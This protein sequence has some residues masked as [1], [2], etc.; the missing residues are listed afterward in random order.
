MEIPEREERRKRA[1]RLF[2]KIMAENFPNLRKDMVVKIQDAQKTTS[3][4]NTKRH[5]I[6]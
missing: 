3:I 5:I 4:I 1:V 6:K 2:E